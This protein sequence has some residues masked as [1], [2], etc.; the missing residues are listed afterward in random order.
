MPT[1]EPMFEN[2]HFLMYPDDAKEVLKLREQKKPLAC[3]IPLFAF[4]DWGVNKNG[5][6]Y[7]LKCG[8][9]N[10]YFGIT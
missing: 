4:H 8:R 1:P 10:F 7:C 9:V 3:Y 6:R 5:L 2:I